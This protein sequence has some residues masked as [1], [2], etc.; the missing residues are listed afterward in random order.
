MEEGNGVGIHQIE[1]AKEQPPR[2]QA[3]RG[4]L[5]NGSPTSRI[6]RTPR[7]DGSISDR[8]LAMVVATCPPAH[9]VNID[10]TTPIH[11]SGH[12]LVDTHLF[13]TGIPRIHRIRYHGNAKSLAIRRGATACMFSL[14]HPS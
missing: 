12:E 8:I 10:S 5:P 1:G 4:S 7:R 9:R 6:Q 14:H 3:K 11:R 13:A 2:R